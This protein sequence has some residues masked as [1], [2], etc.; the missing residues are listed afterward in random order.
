MTVFA[1]ELGVTRLVVFLKNFNGYLANLLNYQTI[2][3]PSMTLQ[4][5][6]RLKARSDYYGLYATD[7]FAFNDSTT[8]NY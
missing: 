7:N 2:T 5:D 8:N 1:K 3:D 6:V 4:T